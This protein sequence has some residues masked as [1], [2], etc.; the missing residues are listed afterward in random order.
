MVTFSHNRSNEVGWHRSLD[1]IFDWQLDH[2]IKSSFTNNSNFSSS[3]V[4]SLF[5]FNQLQS[6]DKPE[7]TEQKQE[8]NS[9]VIG[10]GDTCSRPQTLRA[11]RW[12][13]WPFVYFPI[14]KTP[15]DNA[16]NCTAWA[17]SFHRCV[18]LSAVGQW[19]YLYSPSSL[20]IWPAL[21]KDLK[22]TFTKEYYK[23]EK[24]WRRTETR[25]FF[26]T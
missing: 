7:A 22:E 14:L 15:E 24:M 5:Y 16:A 12:D 18:C 25:P 4:Y 19:F 1:M 23:K 8:H 26:V 10:R 11:N 9:P 21:S 13:G 17:Q 2:P 6:V 3:D 20:E